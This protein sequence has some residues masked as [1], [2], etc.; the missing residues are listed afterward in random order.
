M[1]KAYIKPKIMIED[2]IP[3][4]V[5]NEQD[6]AYTL[7][8]DPFLWGSDIFI[9]DSTEGKFELSEDYLGEKTYQLQ[10]LINL[11]L[12]VFPVHKNPPMVASLILP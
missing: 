2:I 1:K 6:S 9:I 3:H 7:H 12:S 8:L 4:A 5:Y 10:K 11:M